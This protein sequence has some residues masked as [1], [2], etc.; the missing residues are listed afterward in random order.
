MEE[1]NKPKGIFQALKEIYNVEA[2]SV[3]EL[4]EAIWENIWENNTHFTHNLEPSTRICH[5]KKI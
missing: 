5:W 1:D 2:D 4:M 3:D